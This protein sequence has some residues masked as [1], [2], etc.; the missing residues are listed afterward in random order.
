MKT[1]LFVLL[2]SLMVVS[3]TSRPTDYLQ[4]WQTI[5]KIE[6]ATH[7]LELC[8]GSLPTS[9]PPPPSSVNADPESVEVPDV[10]PTPWPLSP[11]LQLIQLKQRLR[12][13]RRALQECQELL[14]GVSS[15]F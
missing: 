7:E 14:T 13:V 8:Q 12:E 5:A 2:V 9:R 6:L 3:I 11:A 10:I 15:E 4:I 1:Q